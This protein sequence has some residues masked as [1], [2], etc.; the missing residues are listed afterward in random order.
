MVLNLNDNQ[1]QHSRLNHSLYKA[2]KQKKKTIPNN[3]NKVS[4]NFI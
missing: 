1:V 4:F 3:Q 2:E